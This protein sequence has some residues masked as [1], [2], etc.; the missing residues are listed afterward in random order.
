M[1]EPSF[2]FFFL[3]FLC[4]IS[5]SLHFS[6]F[7]DPLADKITLVCKQL[8]NETGIFNLQM[9]VPQMSK[10]AEHHTVALLVFFFFFFSFL[11][12][13]FRWAFASDSSDNSVGL[14]CM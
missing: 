1:H 9:G 14:G 6:F 8:Q 12:L 7:S 4:T 10:K 5:L 13:N 2:L 11:R 3:P